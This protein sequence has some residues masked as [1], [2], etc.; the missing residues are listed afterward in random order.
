MV[1]DTENIVIAKYFLFTYNLK[2]PTFNVVITFFHCQDQHVNKEMYNMTM[3]F[4][5]LYYE[6]IYFSILKMLD[7]Y[8]NM[9]TLV[10]N[11][12]IGFKSFEEH[13]MT[14]QK[15]KQRKKMNSQFWL[16]MC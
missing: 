9:T 11:K 16:A 2:L 7:T 5:G 3:I 8:S 10:S 14:L 6:Y 15:P 12:S 13:F 4:E 1:V